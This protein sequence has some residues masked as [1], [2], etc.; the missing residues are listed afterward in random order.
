MSP[1]SQDDVGSTLAANASAVCGLPGIEV[2]WNS[3]SPSDVAVVAEAT[4]GLKTY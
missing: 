4:R 1:G 3:S 2:P